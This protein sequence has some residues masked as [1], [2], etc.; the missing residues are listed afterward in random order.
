MNNTA[1]NSID[2]VKCEQKDSIMELRLSRPEALNALSWKMARDLAEKLR[3]LS[4]DDSVCVVILSGSGDKSFCVGADIKERKGMTEGEIARI[5][6]RWF[7]PLFK[8]SLHR[9]PKPLIA[10]VNGYAI[11]GGV[12]LALGCDLIIASENATFGFK[13]VKLGI[14]PSA[15]ACQKLS[16]VVGINKARELILRGNTISAHKAERIG[17]VNE[18]VP[19]VDLMERVYAVAEE[20]AGGAPIALQ[21]AKKLINKS[22]YVDWAMDFG[23]E[24]SELCY[25][26]MDRIEGA[27]AFVEKR[28]PNFKGE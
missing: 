13:E 21:E 23:G 8:D 5:R 2:L 4:F 28:K 9:F 15:G 12:E 19:Q 3:D 14:I 24:V 18:V 1:K 16:K 17:L 27:K 25:N 6:R 26:T 11:G 22:A 10:A 7:A 20:I